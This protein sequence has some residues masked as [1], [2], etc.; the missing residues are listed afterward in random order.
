MA[1]TDE[2][3]RGVGYVPD[4][5][6]TDNYRAACGLMRM[7]QVGPAL[8]L[9]LKEPTDSPCRGLALAH[10][11]LAWYRLGKY[12]DAIRE[13]WAAQEHFKREGCP[14]TPLAIAAFRTIPD[15]LAATSREIQSLDAYRQTI[16][17]A[18]TLLEEERKI[19]CS[20]QADMVELELA[21]TF[22]HFGGAPR[23]RRRRS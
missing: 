15:S 7:S 14:L 20:N 1:S 2:Q 22:T 18:Q 11:A 21:H 6:V 23:G 17:L 8:E 3:P 9:L 10:A 19:E 13:A 16:S 12:E 4:H 5:V